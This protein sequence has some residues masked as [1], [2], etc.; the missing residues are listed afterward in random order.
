MILQT[1]ASPSPLGDPRHLP[2]SHRAG[3]TGC[4]AVGWA[5]LSL[6][7]KK[8]S[9]HLQSAGETRTG[10]VKLNCRRGAAG[11]GAR[12]RGELPARDPNHSMETWRWEGNAVA[13]AVLGNPSIPH[14][15]WVFTEAPRLGT[16][17]AGTLRLSG[18]RS[19]GNV[20][21][22]HGC[23]NKRAAGVSVSPKQAVRRGGEE[24][25]VAGSGF[26][27]AVTERRA[28]RRCQESMAYP[29]GSAAL[30]AAAPELWRGAGGGKPA[31]FWRGVSSEQD[32]EPPKVS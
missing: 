1:A 3:S 32:E 17:S 18:E 9:Q 22:L 13:A 5:G 23:W 28:S 29:P 8:Y 4:E 14:L 25:A 15:P 16:A 7:G 21:Q 27:P 2:G 24:G 19:R 20:G 31:G 30:A 6:Q 12:V 10:M 26:V 11:R